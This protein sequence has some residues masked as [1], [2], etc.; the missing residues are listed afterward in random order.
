[1]CYTSLTRSTICWHYGS[2][3]A[4]HNAAGWR[5]KVHSL[6]AVVCTE[7]IFRRSVCVGGM[8]LLALKRYLMYLLLIR[9]NALYGMGDLGLYSFSST[10]T[11]VWTYCWII[12]LTCSFF[13]FYISFVGAEAVPNAADIENHLELGKQFLARNQ[14]SDALTH[15]H[16]AVGKCGMVFY[17]SVYIWKEGHGFD[18]IQL[19]L[20]LQ[21]LILT[22]I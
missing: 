10:P 3:L 13:V 11:L 15:Y 22:T 20:F 1:M 4:G 9:F 16:A 18:Y 14:L 19:Y 17:C 2:I 5:E 21:R 6:Y 12:E 7:I 8:N